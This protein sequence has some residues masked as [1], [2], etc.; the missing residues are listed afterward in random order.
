MLIWTNYLK[1]KLLKNV[2]KIHILIISKLKD[3]LLRNNL[4]EK[5]RQEFS[6]ILLKVK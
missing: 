3:F 6:V 5:L 4:S 1:I 2:F